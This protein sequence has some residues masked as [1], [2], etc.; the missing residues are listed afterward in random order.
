MKLLDVHTLRGPNYWSTYWHNITEVKLDIEKLEELPTN[1]I[2]GFPERLFS[3]IPSLNSHFCSEGHVGGF[4]K[5]VQEGTWMAHVAEHI[6]LELQCLAGM[7]CAFGRTR[8]SE[9]KG[10]YYVAFSHEIPKAGQ[11][12]I[13]AALNIVEHII[14]G[15]D[16]NL[17]KD[18]EELKT[19]K[20]REGVGVSTAAIIEEAKKRNIPVRKIDEGS[21]YMLGQGI[22]QRRISASMASTTSGIGIDIAC[23]KEQTKRILHK[24]YIPVPEG[25]SVASIEELNE[26]INHLGYPLVIKPLDGNHGNGVTINIQTKEDA[27]LAFNKAIEISAV[28]VVERF[29]RGKDFR[30][31]VINNKFVAASQRT[32][33]MVKGNG[34]STIRQLVEDLNKDPNRG[35]GHAKALTTVKIDASTEKVLTQKGLSLESAPAVEEV[36]FLKDTANLST[37]G[38]STDVTD[39]IHPHNILLAE[40]ISRIID[41]DICGIDIV[42][43]DITKPLL[44]DNGCIIEVNACPGLRMHLNPSKG[45][46]CNVAE[47]IIS[48]LFPKG[49]P[50]RIPI[51]AVTGT[52]GKTTTTRLMAHIAKTAGQR[53]G[54]TTTDGI[55]INDEV[56]AYGDCTGEASAETV[57]TDSSVDFAVLE[58]AR[59]GILRTGL[60]FDQCDISIITN[61][62]ED[63]LGLNGINSLGDM[64][65][66]KSVV[67]ESTSKD[68]YTIL[69]AEDDEVFFMGDHVDCNIALFALNPQNARVE[70]HCKRGGLAAV[71][72][73]DELIIRR[74]SWITTICKIDDVPLTFSGRA[75]CMV[76]NVLAAVLAASIYNFNIDVI[77]KALYSFIPSPQNTPGRFNIFKFK[78]Y[79]IMVDY[80]HNPHA[81]NELKKFIDRTEA[82]QKIGIITAPGDRRDEDIVQ[83]G[84]FAAQMFDEIIIRLDE[85]L[86][87]RTPEDLIGLLQKGIQSY[88]PFIPVAIVPSEENA[89]LC[90]VHK[91][92][93]GA[94]ITSLTEKV[95]K[96][97]DFVEILRKND[98]KDNI[99]QLNILPSKQ[100]LQFENAV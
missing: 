54:F 83:V 11:Y 20:S 9:K 51:I 69:N 12:A 80:A 14:A 55:Y 24:A 18:I 40:R 88:K 6:A 23:D 82:S 77:K 45:K 85:D 91:A 74:G 41:L 46:V 92:K 61:V 38:T 47:P 5:R 1:K 36:I 31:L 58:C 49:T 28:V 67:A 43:T 25:E 15:K 3:L 86:R 87:G 2:E 8:S 17:S 27:V 73:N 57:L 29:I 30:F 26:S 93:S 78:K 95:W 71:V 89:I 22:H 4:L 64:A 59:G 60:G 52:N 98:A 75:E 19:I 37:G 81:M 90:A 76:K 21:M 94:F 96:T 65:K 42:A 50:S 7:E 62:A 34:H 33:A 53:V 44:P 79:T 13:K 68:G 16:Y 35:N 72:Q 84:F 48:M 39:I 99:V 66:I 63:H 10:I 32:P 100:L 97:I 56:V 70:R